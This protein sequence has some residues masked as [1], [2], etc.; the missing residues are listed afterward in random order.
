MR[1]LIEIIKKKWIR[2]SLLTTSL[3][4]ILIAIFILVNLLF[5]NLDI[6]PLDF[7][8]QKLYTLSDESKEQIA[9][10]Q[11]N[12]TMYFFGYDEASTAITLAKQYNDVNNKISIQII[13]TSERPDLAA[14][15]N[16]STN[17]QLVAV[18]ATE[19]Y[20]IIDSSEMYTFDSSSYQYIDITEQK[21]TNAILDVTIA[22]KPQIYFLTG[23]HT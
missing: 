6:A 1:K 10:V 16:V 8:Q 3:I 19:R 18:Q 5:M 17:S 23:Q 2:D 11:Q 15:Y 20:K 22:Q 4:L 13:D 14:Q 21:L 12:V 9:N 7:T